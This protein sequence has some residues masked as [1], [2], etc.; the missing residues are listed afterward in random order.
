MKTKAKLTSITLALVAALS[1]PAV[2]AQEPTKAA[3]S[4]IPIYFQPKKAEASDK[5]YLILVD[6]ECTNADP[7]AKIA[8]MHWVNLSLIPSELTTP[9]FKR[10]WS[11]DSILP[12]TKRVPE[13][14]DV[15]S[16][17]TVYEVETD[18][19]AAVIAARGERIAEAVKESKDPSA[20]LLKERSAIAYKTVGGLHT[21]DNSPPAPYGNK[22]TP[23]VPEPPPVP[24]TRRFLLGVETNLKD[25]SQAKLFNDWYDKIHI[26]EVLTSP[27]YRAVQRLER[28]TKEAPGRGAVNLTFYEIHATDFEAANKTRD[29]RRLREMK[30]GGY[31][32]GGM[33]VG[34][35]AQAYYEP[36]GEVLKSKNDR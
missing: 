6:N 24:G 30:I 25:E 8:L 35:W 11:L 27:G 10:A 20:A 18:D 9:G 21:R 33:L 2:W 16:F 4:A 1:A 12:L 29:E 22:A 26:P 19:I 14:G 3:S 32:G 13:A 31:D 28:V 15:G 34:P 17:L 7:M 5:T 23:F 36:M